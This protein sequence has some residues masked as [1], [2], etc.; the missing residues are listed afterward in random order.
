MVSVRSTVVLL[1]L[2]LAGACAKSNNPAQ[3]SSGSSAGG[4]SSVTSSVVAPQPVAPGNA[5]QVRYADQPVVLTVAN[6]L[7]TGNATATYTF[8]VATDQA[9]S[10]KVQIKDGVAEG[11]NGQTAV[12]LDQLAGSS[13]YYWHVRAQGGGT[14]GVFSPAYKFSVG[15]AI[16]IQRPAQISPASG[17]TTLG[18][19]TFTV[20][21]AARSGPAGPLTY[22]FEIATNSSFAPILL[23]GI[24]P[25][26][27]TA[28]SF[29]PPANTTAP[30]P[31]TL[32]WRATALDQANGV[33]SNASDTWTFT[34]SEPTRAGQIA[35][36]AGYILWPGAQ[37]TGTGG[38]IAFGDGWNVRQVVS[39]NGVAHTAPT[40][41]E[42]RVLDLLDRGMNPDTA[43]AWM[44]GNGYFT[45]AVYYAGV[46][47]DLG[48][49]GFPYEYMAHVNG[50]WGLVV[51]VGA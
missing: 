38:Q 14:T 2:A 42:L 21:N 17:T 15:P 8:E 5:S 36:Q 51:R 7:V 1:S 12:R 33:I 50:A 28:T 44:N 48:V 41:D 6:G 47:S 46:G 34:Y 40:L 19:P 32:Y 16:I 35:T 45:S 24:V 23:T 27:P 10:N 26:T 29:T 3:P 13:D 43:L 37:P 4:G 11:T 39:F 22:R 9:F 30:T 25:E 20:S 49:I 31:R 18:W